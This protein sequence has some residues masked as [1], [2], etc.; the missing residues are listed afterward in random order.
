MIKYKGTTLY[1]PALQDVLS[2]FDEIKL[3][4]IEIYSNELGTDEILIR[5]VSIDET[6]DFLAKIKDRFR[7]KMRVTPSIKFENFETLQT[8]I[9][10]PESRKP[11]TF[12]DYRENS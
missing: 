9:F 5:L 2:H 8:V 1:P 10:K 4:L 11:I 6:D 7:A 12:I 3:H